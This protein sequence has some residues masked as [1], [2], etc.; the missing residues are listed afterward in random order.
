[1]YM[2]Y[3]RVPS[4]T[5]WSGCEVRE[6]KRILV[7]VFPEIKYTFKVAHGPINCDLLQY[8][9]YNNVGFRILAKKCYGGKIK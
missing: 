5:A 9:E 1:M 6:E 8:N 4:V 3:L 7:V 2:L